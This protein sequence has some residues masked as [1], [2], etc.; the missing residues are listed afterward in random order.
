MP[1]TESAE[2]TEEEDVGQKKLETAE[3]E[4]KSPILAKKTSYSDKFD[5]SDTSFDKNE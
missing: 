4:K 2:K 5:S 3:K 1:A